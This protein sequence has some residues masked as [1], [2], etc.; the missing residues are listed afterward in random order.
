MNAYPVS[1]FRL[2]RVIFSREVM[3]NC[4]KRKASDNRIKDWHFEGKQIRM[5]D[6]LRGYLRKDGILPVK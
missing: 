3:G 1:A 6:P 5:K 2:T 4:L